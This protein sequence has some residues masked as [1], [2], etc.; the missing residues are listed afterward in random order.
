MP[1]KL[2]IYNSFIDIGDVKH[3]PSNP[4]GNTLIIYEQSDTDVITTDFFV[5]MLQ[6]VNLK[7]G[8]NAGLLKCYKENRIVISEILSSGNFKFI[9]YFGISPRITGIMLN[10]NQFKAVSM[11]EIC[12]AQFPSLHLISQNIAYKKN[13][14]ETLKKLYSK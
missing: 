8:L 13:L 14:W 2:N 9:L 1:L 6:A 5:K 12:F 7:L 10:V 11:A 3:I 4:T